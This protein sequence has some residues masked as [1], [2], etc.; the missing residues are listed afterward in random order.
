MS[1]EVQYSSVAYRLPGGKNQRRKV[2]TDPV[3]PD[4]KAALAR[5]KAVLAATHEVEPDHILVTEL[6]PLVNGAVPYK[7]DAP[8]PS[9][10]VELPSVEEIEK[11]TKAQAV[12]LS[13]NLMAAYPGVSIDT[14]Q[15]STKM[16]AE[17]VSVVAQLSGQQASEAKASD[18]E[19]AAAQ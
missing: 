6:T 7:V 1:A 17:L 5:V 19:A 13:A 16:K 14:D 11:L 8:A 18:E 10:V 3:G 2:G 4:G 9:G 12:A 15:S